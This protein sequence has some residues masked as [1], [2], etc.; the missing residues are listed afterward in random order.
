MKILSKYFVCSY[1]S[2]S[3]AFVMTHRVE[4][5]KVEIKF[6]NPVSFHPHQV[7]AIK[8][9]LSHIF[10]VNT[11][12]AHQSKLFTFKLKMKPR[13]TRLRI[14]YEVFRGGFGVTW[15]VL[16]TFDMGREGLGGCKHPANGELRPTNQKP[17]WTIK[18]FTCTSTLYTVGSMDTPAATHFFCSLLKF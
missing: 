3:S 15:G 5:R 4:C 16:A 17:F 8:R 1:L 6:E 2:A 13:R 11:A 12:A 18:L 10:R 7:V 14:V 9:P